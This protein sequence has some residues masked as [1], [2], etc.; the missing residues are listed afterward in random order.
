MRFKIIFG[1]VLLICCSQAVFAQIENED[2][3]VTF[4]IVEDDLDEP[5]GLELP[6]IAI[7]S[8][9][10]PNNPLLLNDYSDLGKKA[11][12]LLD[13]TFNE[14]FIDVK[15]DNAPKYFTKDKAVSKEFGKD[16]YL[17]ELRTGS[18]NVT[19][20]YRDHEYVDGD[21]VRI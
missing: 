3:S 6:P 16:Q 5:S 21:R 1:I 14:E 19:I 8:I 2:N 15:T 13:M 18:N 20:M 10:E 11:T 9:I 4:E 7:P 12:D 17:G